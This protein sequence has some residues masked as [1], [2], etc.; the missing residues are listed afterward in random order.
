ML[1][2][3]ECVF[4]FRP[5]ASDNTDGVMAKFKTDNRGGKPSSSRKPSNP[6]R[7]ARLRRIAIHA[8]AAIVV[9]AA[10]GVGFALVER[11]VEKGIAFPAKP[12]AV[13]LK[14]RPAWMSDLVAEQVATQVAPRGAHSAFDHDMLVEITRMLKTNPWIL[15]VRGV[16]RVY[17]NA[18]GDT[19]EIDCDFR[20]PAALVKNG[21]AYYLIDRNGVRL[22]EQYSVTD[23]PKV[24]ETADGRINMLIIEGVARPAPAGAGQKWTG[25]DL[26]A[27]LDLAGLLLDPTNQA[28]THEVRKINVAN[29]AGRKDAREAHLVLVTKHGTEVRWGRPV[30]AVDRFIEVDPGRK[31]DYLK[32]VYQQ[33]G[34]VD[35][36]QPYGID[37]RY[38]QVRYWSLDPRS[39]QASTDEH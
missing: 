24:V 8:G 26:R 35:A 22:P 30:K 5:R 10:C 32:R 6:E 29:F 39:A 21:K 31:L 23:V 19:L 15:K 7:A 17:G 13:V 4:S 27:G 37:I 18:P 36:N 14:N 2:L 12:P 16:R 34:R 33:Y 38:D 20:T 3:R 25:D 9:L 1:R 28:F 11:H